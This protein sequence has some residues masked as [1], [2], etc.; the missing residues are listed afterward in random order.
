MIAQSFYEEKR[1]TEAQEWYRKISDIAPEGS[2]KQEAIARIAESIFR[3]AEMHEAENRLKEAAEQYERVALEFPDSRIADVA[4]FN[5][6]L[7][8]EKRTEWTNAIL[9]FQRIVQKYPSSKL[10]AKAQ[11]RTAR[12]QE[13]LLKW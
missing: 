9:S 7:A 3:F 2:S 8:H 6:G 13:R 5:A 4:L 1:F 11:F 10:T 12:A